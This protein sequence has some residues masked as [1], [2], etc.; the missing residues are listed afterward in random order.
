MVLD[1][2]TADFFGHVGH[3]GSEIAFP[4]LPD[5]MA[6]RGLHIQECIAACVKLGKAVTPIELFPVIQATTPGESNIIVLFGDDESANWRCFEH[7]I[8]TSTGVLEGVGRRCL[9]AVA[10]DHGMIFDPD[11]DHYPYSR[12]AC[13]SRGFHPRRAWRVDLLHSPPLNPFISE[14]LRKDHTMSSYDYALTS[15]IPKALD[16]EQNEQFYARVMA[17]DDKAREEMI[18]GNMPLVIAKV[19][20]YIGCHPQV[21]YLRD[22][23]HSAGFLALVKAVNTMAEH[24]QPSNVN[25]TGY[26]SV[27]IT[28]EITRVIEKESAMGLTSIP[29]SEEGP[30][31]DHDVPQVGHDIPDSTSDVNES[32]VQGLFE[33]RDVLQSCCESDKERTLL[34]MREEG[35]SDREIAETLDLPHI[36]TFRLRKELEERFNQK[37]RELEE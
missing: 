1:I 15:K 9:H 30:V 37:C 23:L 5:P 10:Y 14:P 33:M 22:D 4:M 2:S 36:T 16:R 7:A 17:G 28:H 6:R 24:D 34:R 32:A 31:S 11:G 12:P 29:E 27:A 19:D 35:Y 3:D 25:P 21:A 8:Q 20:A 18:E 26:I 13:E